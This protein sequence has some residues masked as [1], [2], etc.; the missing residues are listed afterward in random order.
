M[1]GFGCVLGRGLL[2]EHNQYFAIFHALINGN[3]LKFRP[4]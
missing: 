2:A 1:L 3:V 4:V